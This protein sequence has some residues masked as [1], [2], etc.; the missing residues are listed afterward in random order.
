MG[1]RKRVPVG[2]IE[3]ATN[4]GGGPRRDA[5]RIRQFFPNVFLGG[6]Q[7]CHDAFNV[8]EGGGGHLHI[9]LGTS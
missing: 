3:L 8:E 1:L 5:R 2:G 6:L 7:R 9:P 4:S